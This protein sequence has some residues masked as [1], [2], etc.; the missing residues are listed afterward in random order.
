MP[1]YK[2]DDSIQPNEETHSANS[3]IPFSQTAEPIPDNKQQIKNTNITPIV[4]KGTK[5]EEDFLLEVMKAY[6]YYFGKHHQAKVM[7]KTRARRVKAIAKE[8]P[9]FRKVEKWKEYFHLASTSSLMTWK[10]NWKPDLDF[11]LKDEKFVRMVEG[12]YPPRS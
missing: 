1:E 12:Q 10:D 6:N 7:G 8:Y 9:N 4:P 2:I 11:L 3:A 5:P